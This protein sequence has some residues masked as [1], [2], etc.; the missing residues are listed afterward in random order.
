MRKSAAAST[1]RQE[2]KFKRRICEALE[3]LLQSPTLSQDRGFELPA[4]YWDALA[5][6]LVHPSS[7]DK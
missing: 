7:R 3:I 2:N 5:R 4:L 1:D 6:D